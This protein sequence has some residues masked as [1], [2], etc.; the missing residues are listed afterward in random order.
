MAGGYS[1]IL[2]VESELMSDEDVDEELVPGVLFRNVIE[3]KSAVDTKTST[4]IV[5]VF[6]I[7]ILPFL[8]NYICIYIFFYIIP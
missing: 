2:E 7:F 6:F 5:S 3:R 1:I 4:T 8:Q